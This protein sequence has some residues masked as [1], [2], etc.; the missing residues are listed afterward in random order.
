LKNRNVHEMHTWQE[1]WSSLS[2]PPA[3]LA[4]YL[5]ALHI[6]LDGVKN[7]A[8]NV[9]DMLLKCLS[10]QDL[11][12]AQ[13]A[14]EVFLDIIWRESSRYKVIESMEDEKYETFKGSL[15]GFLKRD[16]PNEVKKIV[17][18]LLKLRKETE[19]K[20]KRGSFAKPLF[21]KEAVADVEDIKIDADISI[22]QL[23]ELGFFIL[24]VPSGKYREQEYE[25]YEV[26]DVIVPAPYTDMDILRLFEAPEEPRVEGAR[27]EVEGVVT[28]LPEALKPSRE[29]LEDIVAQALRALGFRA[30]TNFRLPAKGGD[31]EVDVWATKSVGGAQFRVYASCKNWDKD[32]DRHVVDH[33]FGRVLQLHQLPHLR[34][35]VVKSLTEPAK[36][37]A[38][39]DGFFV[40]ELG[41]KASTS[42]AQEIYGI[43]Y[44]KLKEIFIGIAP[45]RV[46]S[47]VE[48]L[49]SALKELEGL[50]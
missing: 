28:P 8:E 5:A 38:F 27:A 35:L 15:Y 49:R 31:V 37:A 7:V 10:P 3:A 41:E 48:R 32:V 44:S 6:L 11:V 34:I 14:L 47:V 17:Q 2:E 45:D 42:N 40:I 24:V 4:V 26:Y 43:V 12:K 9:L 21:L 19:L 20:T 46:R 33:E 16:K 25:E 23:R 18:A 22:K 1:L 50:M 13:K 30:Q 36:K 39:D 29:V